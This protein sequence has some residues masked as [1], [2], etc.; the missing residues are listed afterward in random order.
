MDLHLTAPFTLDTWDGVADP[1][2]A[3]PQA[4]PGG[5]EG[6]SGTGAVAHEL[7]TLD[8]VLPG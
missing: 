2:P 4:P 5:L 8:V 1:E 7:L 6:L 3:D